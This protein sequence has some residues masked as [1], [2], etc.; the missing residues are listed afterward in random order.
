MHSGLY[1]LRFFGEDEDEALGTN[2]RCPKLEFTEHSENGGD[3]SSSIHIDSQKSHAKT[4]IDGLPPAMEEIHRSS[5]LAWENHEESDAEFIG[6]HKSTLED[7]RSVR[8][9][10]GSDGAD[11]AIDSRSASILSNAETNLLI[12]MPPKPLNIEDDMDS[13]ANN[14]DDDEFGDGT[15]WG[16]PSFLSSVDGGH[17]SIHGCKEEHQNAMMEAMNGPFKIL[18]SRL[19][20]S[21]G[22]TSKGEDGESWLDIVVSLSWEAALLVK[23]DSGEGRAMDAGSY[24]KV[25]CIATGARSQSQVIKGLVFKK[26]TAHKHMPTKCRNP[27]LLLLKGPLGQRDIGLSSFD[28]MEQDKEYLRSISEML[29]TCHPNVVLVEKNVSR[30]MQESLLAKGMTLALDMK[31]SRLERIARCA[32][33]EIISASDI[34]ANPKLKHCDSFR[35]EKFVEEHS[36]PSGKKSCK[37]LMFLEGF[38]KPLGCTILLKG[39]HCDELKKIKRVVQYTVFAA[40]RLILE[41]SF[42]ADQRAFSCDACAVREA[43]CSLTDISVPLS[44]CNAAGS[45]DIF[46]GSDAALGTP[47][48]D[49]SQAK[50]AHTEISSFSHPGFKG[51]SESSVFC[52]NI[53]CNENHLSHGD[54]S[55]NRC[56]NDETLPDSST[57]SLLSSQLMSTFSAS[58]R[59]LVGDSYQPPI[60]EHVSMYLGF[61]EEEL[62]IPSIGVLPVSPPTETL[63]HGIEETS[64]VILEKAHDGISNGEKAERNC[65]ETIKKHDTNFSNKFEMQNKDDI[66]SISDSE[67]ILVLLS[68]Q[69]MSKHVVC[70]QSRLSRIK[71][72]GNFDV[73]LGRFL[74]EIILNQNYSCSSCGEPPEAHVSCYT[75]QNGN[76]TVSSRRLPPESSLSGEAEGKIWMWTRCL[77]CEN[78]SGIPRST[79]R[80]VMSTAARGLSFGKFLELSFTSHSAASRLSSG[81]GHSLHR[82]C[83]RFFGLGSRVAMFRYSSVEIYAA[84]KPPPVLEFHNP[85]GQE[86][87]MR[88]AKDVLE[89]GNTFFLE[90]AS[91]LH[92]LKPKY[93]TLVLKKFLNFP[94]LVKDI[95]ELDEMLM[96]E[97]SEF[98]APLLKAINCSGEMGKSVHEILGLGWLFQELLLKLYIWDRRLHFLLAYARDN[99]ASSNEVH[100]DQFVQAK[101]AMPCSS[102]E[103][104]SSSDSHSSKNYSILESKL[105]AGSD[106]LSENMSSK[107]SISTAAEVAEA[108]ILIGETFSRSMSGGKIPSAFD[109]EPYKGPSDLLLRFS[110]D[111]DY[112]GE[113]ATILEYMQDDNPEGWIWAPS[114][115]TRSAYKKDLCGGYS[116]KFK[117]VHTYTPTHLSPIRQLV[118]RETEDSLHFPVNVDGNVFSVCDNEISSI[119]AC[120]LALSEDQFGL[121]ANV[122]EKDELVGKTEAKVIDNSCSSTSDGSGASSYWSSTGSLD[123]EGSHVSLSTSISSDEVPSSGSE[124]SF[125]VDHQV[126]SENMHPEIPVGVGKVTGKSKY[127]VVCLHA[128]QFYALRR[129]C[130]PSELAYISSLSRCKKWNAQGG[131]SKAFFAKTLDD[132]F[133]IKEI[134]KTELDSFLKFAPD[135]FE[136]ICHSLSAGSQTCLAKVLGIYQVKEYKNSKEVKTDLMV[137]ENLL[138]GRNITRKY[139]LKGSIFSRYISDVN[140]PEKVF[141]D[142]N[143][144]EDMQASPMYVSRKTKHLLQRAI[145]NDTSFLTSINVM[146]YSL[147]VGVDKQRKELVFGIIDYLR[148]YTWDKQLETWVKA[149]LVVP[150]NASPT[151]IFPK[152]Y[153]KRF[154]KFMSQYF[155][156]VPDGWNSV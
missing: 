26:N 155:L 76:L 28:L 124:G 31:L 72:Y 144:I 126:A 18:V 20:A 54:L 130:C 125:P 142:Q 115:K 46:D 1:I 13:V 17:R 34:L 3:G 25:K 6:V 150:R 41:T 37:T 49:A 50:T 131:K 113:S 146:D 14:D 10:G 153:K 61:K 104:S 84:S 88:E 33:S 91:L 66:E 105:E 132:R 129:M 149:S 90:V 73:S 67:S 152:E 48:S 100:E 156:T 70:E 95:S 62:D 94:C 89:K 140:D 68:S 12:W 117:F 154:R 108:G 110:R 109:Q 60:S 87:L 145:W 57:P 40:Y 107:F 64:S 143:F 111:K 74:K 16:Q 15:K 136:H 65:N 93:S 35:T 59:N 121:L 42:F 96:Q 58:L 51:S 8:A 77:K 44:S 97:K 137:M 92:K 2:Q 55:C 29:E 69:C 38:P 83:L 103:E 21:E 114:F 85:N 128:K 7:V 127:S 139:D 71:Y 30:D 141:L 133:I 119:I 148:Q 24:V 5:S 101:Y 45:A 112:P 53:D 27:R 23:P 32:G 43:N 116:Q 9:G 47:I 135:Y 138:F 52:P 39:S 79:K 99:D 102:V 98:E 122:D 22:I 120:A 11:N 80:V 118:P 75:H 82:D 106:K 36:N 4:T 86:S 147:L 63:N 123:S 19:L 134:K 78:E 56:N 151:V 81:C